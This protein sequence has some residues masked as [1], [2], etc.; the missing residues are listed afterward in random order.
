MDI[1]LG[2]VI[3]GCALAGAWWG[4]LR[5]ATLVA[6]L[7]AAVLGS[8]FAGPPAADL[9]A[10]GRSVDTVV[11][12]A[13]IL[14]VGI[15]VA[16]LVFLAGRGLRKGIEALHL[17]WLDRLGGFLLGAA[18]TVLLLAALLALA[19]LGGHPPTTRWTQRLA[20]LGQAVLS[21]QSHSNRSTSPSTT[22][23]IPTSSGQ[24]PN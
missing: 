20:T 19:A 18:G 15:V 11:R 4:A 22:P 5:M 12:I 13:I 2:L 3:L 8:R 1:V 7:G 14:G 10:G 17:S 6:A 16:L 9:V 23:P 21:A 24:Q